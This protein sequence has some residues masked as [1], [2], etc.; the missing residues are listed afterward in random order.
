VGLFSGANCLQPLKGPQKGK[1]RIGDN[2]VQ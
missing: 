2:L 1:L